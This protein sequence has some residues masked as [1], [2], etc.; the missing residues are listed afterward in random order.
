V[1]SRSVSGIRD[2]GSTA[3]E[4]V[5]AHP[6]PAIMIGAGLVWLL[7]ESRALRPFE[8]RMLRQGKR[9]LG[10]VG[11]TAGS[12]REGLST[13]GEY[14]RGGA[15][16]VREA[17]YEGAN[18][19]SRGAQRGYETTRQTLSQSWGSHP[20]AVCA[21]VL[22]AGVAAAILLPA[23]SGEMRWMGKTSGAITRRVKE[24]GRQLVKQTKRLAGEA[25]GTAG[26]EARRQGLTPRDLGSKVKRVAER[27]R[28]AVVSEATT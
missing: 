14:A 2:A 28:D 3:A 5:A 13:A 18:A 12:L 22:A 16:A 24:K 27:T 4:S 20:L 8:Q 6:I 11:E 21:A 10:T 7:L 19:V 23:T 17:F 25:V 1:L 15:A 9:A 26:R